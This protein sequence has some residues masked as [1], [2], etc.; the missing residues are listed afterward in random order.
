LQSDAGI[1]LDLVAGAFGV[2]DVFGAVEL[3]TVAGIL[4]LGD[5]AWIPVGSR[6]YDEERRRGCGALQS[7]QNAGSAVGIGAVV[8]S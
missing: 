5:Q 6:G 2:A 7:R 8:E 1:L 3:Y 4:D